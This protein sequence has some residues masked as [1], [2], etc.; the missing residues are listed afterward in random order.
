MNT[1]GI[2]QEGAQA[3]FDTLHTQAP[4][5]LF[6]AA[7]DA[8][9]RLVVQLSALGADSGAATRFHASKRAADDALRR[10]PIP[11]V[12]VQPSL[13]YGPNGT[14][15]EFFNRLA[16][17]PVIPVPASRALVHPVH[18]DDLIDSLVRLIEDPPAQSCTVH[19]VGPHP[20]TL[21]SYLLG[22][23]QAL[24]A[25]RGALVLK[26]PLAFAL[27]GARLLA[28][29][30]PHRASL[31]HPDALSMLARG[32]TADPSGF[33]QLLGRPARPVDAFVGEADRRNARERA[34]WSNLLAA[35]RA[36][37]ATVW[38]VTGALSLGLY[39]TAQSLQLLGDFGLHGPPAFAALYLGAALDLCLGLAMLLAPRRWLPTVYRAQILLMLGYSA[40]IT[41]RIPH[42]W[43]HPFG[44]ILKNLPM[45][46]GTAM[47][48][49]LDRRR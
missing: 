45:L 42:W 17:L 15:A 4:V 25:G 12:I 28:A 7:A 10:L 27:L 13:V 24:G 9:V 38:I 36:S 33:A 34:Q 3:S 44:P 29:A 47:L 43:L 16:V 11:S 40:L 41:L 2:F 5:A 21:K 8:G 18:L 26:I 37:T 49:S 39:P 22:L 14:S 31:V 23:R 19:A 20:L 35:M 30:M 46:V 32:N 48:A 1:V 6:Q